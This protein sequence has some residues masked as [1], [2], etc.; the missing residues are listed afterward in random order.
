MCIYIYIYVY[1]HVLEYSLIE[2]Q[3]PPL[4][5]STSRSESLS[6]QRVFVSPGWAIDI[7]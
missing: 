2:M 4:G 6:S 3:K 5:P 1:T 7:I